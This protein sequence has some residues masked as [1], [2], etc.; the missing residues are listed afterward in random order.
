MSIFSGGGVPSPDYDSDDINYVDQKTEFTNDVFVYGKLYADLGGDVQTFST[1]GVE[2]VRITKEGDV[3][4]GS[5]NPNVVVDSSNTSILA[6]GIVTAREYYGVFKG[7]IDPTVANDKISEGNSEAEVVDTGTNGHFKVTTEGVER[8]RITSAGKVGIHTDIANA[9][10]EIG[11]VTGNY[12]NTGGMQ[13][14]R[15]HSLGLSNGVFVYSEVDYNSSPSYN[16]TAFKA[17]GTGGNAFGVSKDQG[18]NGLGGSLTSSI[19]FDGNAVFLGKVGIQTNNPTSGLQVNNYFRS[20]LVPATLSQPLGANWA[21]QSAIVTRG[22]FAGGICLDD[23]GVAGY[24]IFTSGNGNNLHI[25][26][27]LVGQVP[28]EKLLIHADTVADGKIKS[29]CQVVFY[30]VTQTERDALNAQTGGVIYNTN[31][32]KLQCWNGSSWNNLF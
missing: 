25:R 17:V 18:S 2:R 30:N 1:A 23:N 8:F 28:V 16:A 6:V 5:K 32:N 19:D 11:T 7:S 4:I 3:A 31:V 22:D 15:P 29:L 14:N 27:G 24:S 10:L 26:A 13:V 12:M 20:Q 9:Q 21:T